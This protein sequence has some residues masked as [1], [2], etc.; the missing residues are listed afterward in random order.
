MKAGARQDTVL[1]GKAID[2]VGNNVDFLG[3][4]FTLL[5]NSKYITFYIQHKIYTKTKFIFFY[6]KNILN[7]NFLEHKLM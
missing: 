6:L 5:H 4:D 3:H 2:R 1:P 7:L